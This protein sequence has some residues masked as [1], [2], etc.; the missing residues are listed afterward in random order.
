[1]SSLEMCGNFCLKNNI[2]YF[3]IIEEKIKQNNEIGNI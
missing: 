2:F 3:F 1:M